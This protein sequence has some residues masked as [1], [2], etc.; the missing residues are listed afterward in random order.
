VICGYCDA[1]QSVGWASLI[2][3]TATVGI[4]TQSQIETTQILIDTSACD[5]DR[6]N[7]R[8]LSSKRKAK[9]NI[10]WIVCALATRIDSRS[11]FRLVVSAQDVDRIF[12]GRIEV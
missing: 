2:N 3:D 10:E 5:V 11:K 6:G 9:L 8:L 7:Y 12:H 4:L 1:K